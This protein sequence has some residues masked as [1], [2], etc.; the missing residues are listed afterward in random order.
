MNSNQDLLLKIFWTTWQLLA[1][2]DPFRGIWTT[3]EIRPSMT[4]I[5]QEF[6]YNRWKK[7][8]LSGLEGQESYK[9]R[10]FRICNKR[11]EDRIRL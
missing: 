9:H 4:S 11:K 10:M 6:T 1:L 5:R 2:E 8:N 3:T 7:M